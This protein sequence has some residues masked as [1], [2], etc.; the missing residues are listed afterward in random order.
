MAKLVPEM[1][2]SACGRGVAKIG[3]KCAACKVFDYSRGP[4]SL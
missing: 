1:F 2:I 3:N 4:I